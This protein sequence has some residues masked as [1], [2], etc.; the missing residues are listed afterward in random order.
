MSR[1]AR[2][3]LPP[4]SGNAY[5]RD[6]VETS[7][8]AAVIGALTGL[9]AVGVRIAIAFVTGIAFRQRVEVEFLTPRENTLG[10]L[11]ILVPAVGAAIAWVI[12]RLVSQDDR[13][14]GATEVIRSVATRRGRVSRRKLVGHAAATV[15]SVGSGGSAGREGAMVQL[16]ASLGMLASIILG[17]SV[18]HRKILLAAGGAAAIGGTFNT[19]IAG[20]VFAMEVILLEWTT[21]AF[22]PLT[23]ASAMGT[24]VATSLL[25]SEPAFPIPAYE[26]VQGR[27]LWLYLALGIIAGGLAIAVLRS[28]KVSDRIFAR[29]PGPVWIRPILGGL[30]VGVVGFLVPQAFG[31]GYETV[32]DA[33]HGNFIAVNLAII[34]LA[35][36]LAFAITR[37]S[38][39][40]SGAFSPSLF[41][42]SALG[43]VFGAVAATLFPGQTGGA[44]AYALVGMAAVYASVTRASLTAVI[45]LY[46]M[47][48]TFSIVIP[49]MLAIVI[50]DAMSKAYGEGAF[51]RLGSARAA[52]ETDASVNI[53]D[54][55]SVGEIMA[56]DVDTVRAE[57]PVRTVVEKR[58][59]TGHQG[60][61]VRDADDRLVGIITATDMRR[62]VKE[63]DLERPVKDFMT[64][65]PVTVTASVTAHEALTEMV[66]MDM[67][68]LPVVD[69]NDARKLVGFLT[70]S[71]LV[72]VEKRIHEEEEPGEIVIDPRR[73]VRWDDQV[74]RPKE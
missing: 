66:R 58:F 67:G 33:L 74:R 26:L 53:L 43:G 3:A 60:Y 15:V 71:D 28:L 68:H 1:T 6:L 70:R 55:V 38:G 16:G 4:T 5:M 59:A 73:W 61:P 14:R 51:Y 8:L 52:I 54:V 50:A 9:I 24:L 45:M 56:K 22:V 36:L 7:L 10:Y 35:K 2:L 11:V 18:R 32:N 40:A 13:I 49:A 46:E 72:G 30:L 69:E 42:G 31:V 21:R 23:V 17:Q 63:G 57:E 27:E 29:F 48:H 44:G 34:L 39:G 37:G 64:P 25:G 12:V 47:T 65:D 62:K 19:P 20:V 41:L